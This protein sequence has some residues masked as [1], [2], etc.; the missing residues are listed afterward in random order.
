MCFTKNY[1]FDLYELSDACQMSCR[2][3]LR[4][5]EYETIIYFRNIFSRSVLL[6]KKII[7]AKM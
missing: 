7:F 4:D 6:F 3:Y 1:I 5:S 2:K